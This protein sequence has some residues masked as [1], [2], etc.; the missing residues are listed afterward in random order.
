MLT[1]NSGPILTYTEAIYH[2]FFLFQT[3][4]EQLWILYIKLL[5][6]KYWSKEPTV[7]SFT[8]HCNHIP[9]TSHCTTLN[10]RKPCRAYLCW[11]PKLKIWTFTIS[12]F[13]SS[14]LWLSTGVWFSFIAI[15]REHQ[16][17]QQRLLW[18]RFIVFSILTAV[19]ISR[20]PIRWTYI[21]RAFLYRAS[22][23]GSD[24]PPW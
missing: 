19:D 24:L 8:I 22:V 17:F 20:C 3:N 6:K 10:A 18:F 5:W 12:P 13:I 23:S 4:K 16:F 1:N 14:S 11:N 21:E 7:D 2:L 15:Q 9:F